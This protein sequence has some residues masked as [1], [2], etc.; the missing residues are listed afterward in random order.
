MR[1]PFSSNYAILFEKDAVSA[2]SM[3]SCHR[4]GDGNHDL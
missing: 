4:F 1:V 2:G 3:G